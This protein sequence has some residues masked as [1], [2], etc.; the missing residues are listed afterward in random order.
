MYSYE[1]LRL[2]FDAFFK[3]N[4][5]F[6]AQPDNLYE[7]CRYILADSGKRIRPMLCLLSNQMLGGDL[8]DDVFNVAMSL[9]LFHNFTLMHDDIM[10]QAPLRRG[11]PT[12]HRKYGVTAGILSGD[13]MNIYS[14]KCLSEVRPHLLKPMLD[15]FNC[16]AIEV[17][18]GQQLDMDYETNTQASIQDY[19]EMIKLKTSVLIACSLK[20]GA[21]LAEVSPEVTELMYDTGINL[22]MAFQIQDDYLDTFGAEL[23]TGKKV[24]GDIQSN[25]KTFLYL[26]A[27]QTANEAQTLQLDELQRSNSELKV[28][29]TIALYKSL[30]V[31]TTAKELIAKYFSNV[32]ANLEKLKTITKDIQQL[33]NLVSELIR[34]EK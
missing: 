20:A 22:G 12:V 18:E 26:Q 14:Y 28:Q 24:G 19:L 5:P 30:Q 11:K 21:I 7:P 25:K 33:E 16:T 13:V 3:N 31:D 15:L 10:D 4:I 27:Y 2:R 1:E 8:A 32:M 6:H 34:R 29:E 17:C 9:E 23:N